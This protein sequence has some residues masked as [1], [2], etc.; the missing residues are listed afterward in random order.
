MSTG[1]LEAEAKREYRLEAAVF[2]FISLLALWPMVQ[3]GQ[4]LLD[5]I[6]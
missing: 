4:A 1:F 6:K 2:G 5:L 3:A